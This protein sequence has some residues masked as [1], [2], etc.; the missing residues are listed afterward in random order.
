M[1]K[2]I[3]IDWSSL[4]FEYMPVD[5]HIRYTWEDGK[6]NSGKLLK[7][8][9]ITMPIAATCLHYG[10]ECFEGLKA[11]KWKDGSINVFRPYENA[12]RLNRSAERILCPEVPPELFM[13]AI[14]RVIKANIDYVP[15]Y[16]T[17]GSLYIRP[18]LIGTS[19]IIGVAPSKKYEFIVLVIP[20]GNYYKGGISPVK[21]VV[22]DKFDR[23]APHGTGDV[24]VGGNYAASLYQAKKA[25]E[26][27]FPI[28]LYP[29]PRTRTFV[30]EFGTSNFI[31][32]D[33]NGRYVTPL[34]D[35]VLPSITN[36]SLMQLAQDMGIQVERRQIRIEELSDFL[37]VG[38][39]GTAVVITPVSEIHWGE[40]VFKFG[41]QCG[42]TLKKL[43]DKLTG[44]QYGEEPDIHSWLVK[45]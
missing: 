15:P 28:V 45:I 8:H 23:C 19:P 40:K 27:G 13:E 37:E 18:L 33:K 31:A 34:S 21:A 43:Y 39:C 22:S 36:M 30:D 6:W 42:T 35:S 3:N 14:S 29:D 41:E 1:A 11:F 4:G 5:R 7:K 24:K 12:K 26:L 38:A 17:R 10:Q 9:E 25:K 32:I 16:G 2:K 44:I 20:V